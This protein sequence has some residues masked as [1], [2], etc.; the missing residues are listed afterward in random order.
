[1]LNAKNRKCLSFDLFAVRYK[2]SRKAHNL[3]QSYGQEC[4]YQLRRSFDVL[5]VM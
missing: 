5:N 2:I 4:T 1:M 3:L